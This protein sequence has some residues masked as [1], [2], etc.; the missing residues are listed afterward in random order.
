MR[1]KGSAEELERRRRRAVELTDH[2]E[3]RATVA[4]ILGVHLKTLARWVRSARLPEGLAAKPQSGPTA[5]LSDDQLRELEAL[6]LQ[7]AKAHGWHNE[8][9]TAARVA[10]LVERHFDISYHPEHVRKVLKRRLVWTPQK[11]RQQNVNRDDKAIAS[12]V[13]ETFPAIMRAAVARGAD[14]VFVDETGFMLDP[15][16]RRTYAPRGQTPVYKVANPH[17][18]ISVIGGVVV[19]PGTGE[20]GMLYGMLGDNLNFRWPAIAQ[21]VRTLRSTLARPLT[22]IWDRIPIHD[23]PALDEELAKDPEVV[24]ELLPSHAPEVNP[25][26]GI[27][28]YIKHD[29]LPNYAPPDLCEL[30]RM[31]TAELNRL[32]KRPSLLRGF[33]RFTKLPVWGP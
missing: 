5:R 16:V 7:G 29:R 21:F 23:C 28:R 31:V 19:R 4:R 8:L 17:A 3:P 33:I 6:L 1:P 24:A 12:W 13:H 30:R 20:V 32:R 11:P 27:W 15:T 2:G 14:V 10:R 18:C 22:V 9:W 26:D 25:A